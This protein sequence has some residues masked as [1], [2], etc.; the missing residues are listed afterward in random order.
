MRIRIPLHMAAASA[1]LC[2]GLFAQNNVPDAV[3]NPM[4]GDRAAI[5]AGKQIYSSVCQACHGPEARGDR[6]P[7]LTG[8]LRHGNS[9][10]EI[11]RN[12]RGGIQG[13]QMPPF[14]QFTADQIW[15]VMAY[16]RS[17]SGASTQDTAPGD[18]HWQ[19]RRFS[20][21]KAAAAHAI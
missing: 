3:K 21:A 10:S 6:G 13:T 17:L 11:F 12:V 15:Q 18:D 4:E 1:G 5:E 8:S 2:V 7:A 20:T 9:D 19:A 14:A 16:I